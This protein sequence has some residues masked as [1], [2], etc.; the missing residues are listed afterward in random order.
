MEKP[1]SADLRELR[2]LFRHYVGGHQRP[3][4]DACRELITSLT[5]MAEK[6]DGLEAR[7]ADADEM[8]AVARDLDV[9]LSARISPSLQAALKAEQAELQRALDAEAAPFSRPGLA[10]LAV[11]VAG[12]NVTIFP[13]APRRRGPFDSEDGIGGGDAA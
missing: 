10:A 4:I 8:E 11:P 7:A 2:D 5:L 6:A 3:T 9:A 13:L 12:S 1:L